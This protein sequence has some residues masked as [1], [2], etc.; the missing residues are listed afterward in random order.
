MILCSLSVTHSEVYTLSQVWN[1]FY[2]PTDFFINPHIAE[3]GRQLSEYITLRFQYP[4]PL[5]IPDIVSMKDWKKVKLTTDHPINWILKSN[6][7]SWP[8]S[9]SQRW[10]IFQTLSRH[11]GPEQ[12]PWKDDMEKNKWIDR[13]VNCNL[14]SLNPHQP[15][16]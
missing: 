16:N 2:L 6:V 5:N 10:R 12:L 14:P 1:T 8:I 4:K 9:N 3:I 11:Y 7:Y 13:Q 15:P